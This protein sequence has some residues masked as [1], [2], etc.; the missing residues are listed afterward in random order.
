MQINA[1]VSPVGMLWCPPSKQNEPQNPKMY[2]PQLRRYVHRK[3]KRRPARPL[4]RRVPLR[5]P[6]RFSNVSA[7]FRAI[8]PRSSWNCSIAPLKVSDLHAVLGR[9]L[10]PGYRLNGNGPLSWFERLAAFQ[11][12]ALVAW[13]DQSAKWAHSLRAD[14]PCLELRKQIGNDGQP[15]AETVAERTNGL[16]RSTFALSPMGQELFRHNEKRWNDPKPPRVS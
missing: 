2:Q 6:S 16:H 12:R 4:P 1:V 5:Q 8:K 10:G 14:L 3:L 13:R 9:E 11:A 7:L 15:A